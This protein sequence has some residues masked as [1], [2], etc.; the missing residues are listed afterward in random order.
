MNKNLNSKGNLLL[1]LISK[2]KLFK[3][4]KLLVFNVS[5]FKKKYSNVLRNIKSEFKDSNIA[6]RSSASDEDL[7]LNSSAGTYDTVLNIPLKKLNKVKAAITKVVNSYEKKR[8]LLK[9]DHVIIQKM[10]KNVNMSGVIFTHDLNTGAPYYVINYDDQSGLTDTVTSGTTEY[11]NRTLYVHRKSINKIKSKRFSILLKAVEELE[12]IMNSQFLDIEFII[13]KNFVPYLLQVR[14]IT[15]TS[16]WHLI[17]EK[18]INKTLKLLDYSISKKFKKIKGV[19]GKTTIFGQMPDWN[20]IEIIG[21]TPRALSLSLYQTL[22][23]NH[24]WRKARNIMG[25]STPK[26]KKLITVL[27]GQ[28][29]IDTRLSFHSFLPRKIPAKISEKLVNV[30]LERLAKLPH[31]HDKIEFDVSITTFSF[32]IEKKMKNLIGNSLSKN[33]KNIFKMYHLNQTKNLVKGTTSGSLKDALNKIESLKKKQIKIKNIKKLSNITLLP[34]MISDCIHYGTIPFAILARHGFIA[35]TILL[36]LQNVGIIKNENIESFMKSIQTVASEYVRDINALHQKKINKPSFDKIYGH[37]RPGTYDIMSLRYDQ[38]SYLFNDIL[39]KNSNKKNKKYDF[40]IKIK[41][42]INKLLKKNGFVDFDSND[43][44]KYIKDAIIAREYSKFIFTRS[45]SDILEIIS[46]YAKKNGISKDQISH[47]DLN[48][49]LSVLKNNSNNKKKLLKIFSLNEKKYKISTLVR[50]PQVLTNKAGVYVVPFQVSH[51]NFITE[52]EVSAEVLIIKSKFIKKSLKDKIIIVESADPG[53]DWI[54]S[55]KIKGLI[56]KYGGVNSHMAI[57]CAEFD[58][59]AAIGCGEQRFEKI[60]KS[61][62]INLDCANGM[63]NF[64]H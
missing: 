51:P 14:K 27:A 34:K 29:F 47:V 57:R 61:K 6:I 33:E 39:K 19:Y 50:L 3:I 54:F 55:H 45:V 56:T 25:Y 52:K 43:L 2:V 41:H 63:I 8:L 18:K 59:P 15:T 21:R 48:S 12:K 28:P 58:L 44:L 37:L 10:I 22:I 64:I 38:M 5:I 42:Q 31:L 32:D 20:P 60:I 40:S 1:F 36:S 49:I 13:D 30:A 26:N 17:D 11:S 16:K 35:R 46:N 62:K 7:E 53:F 24:A 23:T 4:P 9:N